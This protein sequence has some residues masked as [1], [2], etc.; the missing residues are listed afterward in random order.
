MATKKE[1]ANLAISLFNNLDQAEQFEVER[2]FY[3]LDNKFLLKLIEEMKEDVLYN[4]NKQPKYILN[5]KEEMTK[6]FVA[7]D[8]IIK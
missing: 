1:L 2:L 7:V 4:L 3:H 5:S 6:I 8:K